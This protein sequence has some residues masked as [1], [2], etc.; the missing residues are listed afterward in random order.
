MGLLKDLRVLDIAGNRLQSLPISLINLNLLDALWV[1]G[2][3]VCV[4][5]CVYVRVRVCMRACV[6]V[7]VCTF[8]HVYKIVINY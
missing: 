7:C 6:C 2:G 4:C 8:L 5:V 1:D 3:Q